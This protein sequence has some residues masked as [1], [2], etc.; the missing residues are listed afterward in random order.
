MPSILSA[1]EAL[2]MA[3]DF[4]VDELQHHGRVYGTGGSTRMAGGKRMSVEVRVAA[5]L[6]RGYLVG[7]L[8]DHIR[9]T[10]LRRREYAFSWD[11]SIPSAV[12][13]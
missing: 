1:G 8:Q 7:E 5:Y 6:E 13:T 3:G 2:G 10:T 11:R 9:F 12:A 4:E